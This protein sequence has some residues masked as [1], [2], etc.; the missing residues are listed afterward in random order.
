MKLRTNF[1]ILFLL[2][3]FGVKYIVNMPIIYQTIIKNF[4]Y[5]RTNL[6]AHAIEI[7]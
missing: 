2:C 6:D 3:F 4:I 7:N 1:K 5:L